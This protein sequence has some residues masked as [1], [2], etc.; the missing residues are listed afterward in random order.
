MK[1]NKNPLKERKKEG[2]VALMLLTFVCFIRKKLLD[3]DLIINCYYYWL[4][5]SFSKLLHCNMLFEDFNIL[6]IL[7]SNS[8][9]LLSQLTQMFWVLGSTSASECDGRLFLS[10]SSYQ[11]V[12]SLLTLSLSDWWTLE[13]KSCSK[14]SNVGENISITGCEEL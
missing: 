7:M 12:I 10:V 6:N 13:P 2:F 14:R 3:C 5:D 8:E 4:L 1:G 9:Q 11:S